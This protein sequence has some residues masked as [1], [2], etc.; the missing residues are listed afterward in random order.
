M[1][2]ME[3][4]RGAEEF[5]LTFVRFQFHQNSID[6]LL[7]RNKAIIAS[8]TLVVLLKSEYGM[9]ELGKQAIISCRVNGFRR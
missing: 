5:P 9:I 4:E 3:S 7:S 6:D 8:M 2:D 1:N